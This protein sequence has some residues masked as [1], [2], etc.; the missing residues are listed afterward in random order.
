MKINYTI[1]HKLAQ[2][3]KYM[4]TGDAGADL[5]CIES[6]YLEPGE[7]RL[8]RTGIAIALPDGYAAFV[9]PRSGLAATAGISI[10]NAPGTIDSGYRGEIKVILINH[11]DDLHHFVAGQRIAQLVIQR[12]ESVE[13]CPVDDLE[14]GDRG[15]SGFGSTGVSSL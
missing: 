1:L 4:N 2:A 3:P 13:F 7:Y 11:G 9:H 8:I 6:F 10:V 12:Y 14:S 15:D 5:S